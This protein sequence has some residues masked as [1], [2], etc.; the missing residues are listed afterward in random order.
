MG[1]AQYHSFRMA[2][3]IFLSLLP[4]VFAQQTALITGGFNGYEGAR[5]RC[6]LL[7]AGCLV[8]S[9]PVVSNTSGGTNRSGRSDHI[10]HVT[11]DGVV[12]SCGG[13]SADGTDD[14]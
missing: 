5:D 1:K 4:A 2:A 3:Q 11:E 7:N 14:L 8:P 12:L 9:F 10:T 6:E 13:E